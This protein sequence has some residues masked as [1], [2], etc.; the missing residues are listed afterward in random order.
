MGML[1]SAE[2]YL[3]GWRR[4]HLAKAITYARADE[5]KAFSATQAATEVDAETSEAV[6]VRSE[7][8]DWLIEKT[9]LGSFELPESGD[10]VTCEGISYVVTDLG[11]GRCFRRHGRDG[12]SLR[13]HSKR[14]AS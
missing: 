2:S 4:S 7:T 11:D 10:V 5:D 13:V 14:V 1:E 6:V 3:R 12:L 9:D 8:V